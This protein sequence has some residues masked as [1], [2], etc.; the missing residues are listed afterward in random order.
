[1]GKDG[2]VTLL[3]FSSPVDRF[4]AEPELLDMVSIPFQGLQS[5]LGV[6]GVVENPSSTT[7]HMKGFN[8]V[9]R[10]LHSSSPHEIAREKVTE[11]TLEDL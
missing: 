1:M 8:E 9:Y 11:D 10:G 7:L 5:E 4:L 2:F 6:V 3:E